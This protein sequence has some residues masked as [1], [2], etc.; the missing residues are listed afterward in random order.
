MRF[1]PI[2]A[3]YLILCISASA[4][5]TKWAYNFAGS[6]SS[7]PDLFL[8]PL[9]SENTTLSLSGWKSQLLSGSDF[10]PTTYSHTLSQMVA[11]AQPGDQVMIT[12][13]THGSPTGDDKGHII[14]CADKDCSTSDLKKTIQALERK[15]VRVAVV[16]LS[17]YS[18]LSQALAS[19][20]KA[21]VVSGATDNDTAWSSFSTNFA[22]NISAGRSLEQ[23]FLQARALPSSVG[24]PQ[25]STRAGQYADSLIQE[26]AEHPTMNVTVDDL[27]HQ[28]CAQLDLRQTAE[29]F[30][31]LNDITG[32]LQAAA[33]VNAVAKYQSIYRQ[34]QDLAKSIVK[35]GNAKTEVGITW[36]QLADDDDEWLQKN[37]PT[38]YQI[39]QRL[40]ANSDFKNLIALKKQ[41]D[42]LTTSQNAGQNGPAKSPLAQAAL[43]V[44]QAE[45]PLYNK[46]YKAN[47]SLDT[48]GKGNA[49]AQFVF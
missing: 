15:H 18:G 7:N 6:D 20:T 25:I 14:G 4:Q 5:A 11:A 35:I 16:D 30:Q 44:Q 27:A 1:L 47:R 10:N 39:K 22:T 32:K 49:C 38:A 24:L 45:K 31:D 17:C 37:I 40:M 26:L 33:Y 13:D 36:G 34:A 48:N 9:Q 2:L 19:N 29:S 8:A 3:A 46:I 28:P 43:Q 23:T 41:F 42:A 21:C 12:I